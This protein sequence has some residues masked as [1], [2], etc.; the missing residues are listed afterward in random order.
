MPSLLAGEDE[1][2]PG[3]AGMLCW[4]AMTCDKSTRPRAEVLL[5]KPFAATQKQ[6]A[7]AIVE[8][9]CEHVPALRVDP[10]P[11]EL[12]SFWMKCSSL[13][14]VVLA[15]ALADQLSK[16][17]DEQNWQ[18]QVRTLHILTYLYTKGHGGKQ[19]A[20]LVINNARE[21]LQHL[22]KETEECH[23][24][25]N[26]ALL[27]AQLAGVVLSGC[28]MYFMGG[29]P[30][31]S[32]SSVGGVAKSNRGLKTTTKNGQSCEQADPQTSSA[33]V[34]TSA[35]LFS[36]SEAVEAAPFTVMHP[37]A[38]SVQ[39]QDLICLAESVRQQDLISLDATPKVV[40]VDK[41]HVHVI[42]A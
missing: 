37:V 9:F 42:S 2:K 5:A 15:Q 13:R 10:T 24:E 16:A 31:H 28:L 21:L 36:V 40:D 34:E 27:V 20:Q 6:A 32:N 26:L 39:E 22:A 23:R 17:T 1:A 29:D 41:N 11:A 19:I 35:D 8:T 14:A 25:V 38:A 4:A 33:A 3:W 18:S 7:V 12:E 30:R